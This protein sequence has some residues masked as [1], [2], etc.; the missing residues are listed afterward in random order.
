MSFRIDSRTNPDDVVSSTQPTVL[1]IH[2]HADDE[3]LPAAGTLRLMSQAGWRVHCLILTEGNRSRSSI[4]GTRMDEAA[5]A[6]KV[7]GATYEF[8]NL[9]EC[10]FSS[11]SVIQVT[12]SAI[13][14]WKPDLL[15]THAPQ[16]ESYG[17]RDHTVC[18]AA[19]TNVATRKNI[20]LW[21]SAPP[22]YLRGFEPN[23]FVDITPV[24]KEKIN[25]IRCY[26]S[27]GEKMFMQLDSILVLARFW[28]RELGQQEGYFEA[29]EICRQSV[30]A[31]FFGPVKTESNST[32]NPPKFTSHS[33]VCH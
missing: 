11:Q 13:A 21:Y 31:S 25:A 30:G 18:S 7:I 32:Q 16:P 24:I 23:F 5:A 6:G 33:L 20:S 10:T 12:E 9:E 15:I 28:A 4:K 17:H 1:T 14:K 8:F 29:F 2:A 3:V 27:E 22:V 26:E 19:V